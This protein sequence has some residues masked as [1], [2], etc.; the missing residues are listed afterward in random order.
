M[1]LSELEKSALKILYDCGYRW[2]TRDEM[3]LCVFKSKPELHISKDKSFQ[4]WQPASTEQCEYATLYPDKFSQVG[5]HE[6][7]P[8]KIGEGGTLALCKTTKKAVA[9]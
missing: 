3:G 7:E 6:T 2:M 5:Y 9:V 4:F 1:K 8:Y